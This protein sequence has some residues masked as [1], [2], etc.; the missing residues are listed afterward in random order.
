MKGSLQFL[1]HDRY[2]KTAP[3]SELLMEMRVASFRMFSETVPLPRQGMLCYRSEVK[4]EL[5]RFR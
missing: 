3:R 2:K 4:W 1:L 5:H